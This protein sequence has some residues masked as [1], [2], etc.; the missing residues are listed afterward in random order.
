MDDQWI[1]SGRDAAEAIG[2]FAF[3][4]L[5]PDNQWGFDLKQERIRRKDGK[6][7]EVQMRNRGS[8]CQP[9]IIEEPNKPKDTDII[10]QVV[11]EYDGM[12]VR[13]R[14]V[15]GLNGPVLELM[16][17]SLSKGELVESGRV[18]GKI[19]ANPQRI[20]GGYIEVV[21]VDVVLIFKGEGGIPPWE[22]VRRSTDARS[23]AA[24][25]KAGLL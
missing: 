13:A 18:V 9:A 17:S 20:G 3:I 6:F 22:F 8:F 15:Q 24:L 14:T 21:L 11:I 19:E 4:A 16:P 5:E 12:Y 25:A 2:N 1:I 7:F 23:I 10:G